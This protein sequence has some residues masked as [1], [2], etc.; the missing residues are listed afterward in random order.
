[1]APD[2]HT[3]SRRPPPKAGGGHS[4]LVTFLVLTVIVGALAAVLGAAAFLTWDKNT[5][6]IGEGIGVIPIQGAIIQSEPI[7]ETL[8]EFRR[9][10]KIKI[11]ILRID[12]PGGGVAQTQEIY[13]EIKKTKAKKK[14]IVSMG[15]VAASGGLYVAAAADLVLA[16]AATV[17]GSIGVIM[18]M[19][20]FEDLMGKVGLN[21]VVI[22]SG[23]YKDIG[24]SSRPMTEEEKLILQGVVDQL[25]QQFVADLAQGRGLEVEKVAA[26]A[27]GRIFTGLEAQ[28]LGLVDKIGGFEDAVALAGAMAGFKERGRLIYP[29]KSGSWL[30]EF[31]GKT[32]LG[33]LPEWARQPLTFQYLY[34]PGV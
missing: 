22:K 11:I 12:S 21:S 6:T 1:M 4:C 5:L 19:V 16:N 8:V 3:T 27:D 34:L 29:K 2:S 17:T 31:M 18:Q 32:P 23:R 20:N 30:D 15:S 7:I 14:V 33:I 28:K 25:H 24:S 9:S 26:L 13:R 10:D